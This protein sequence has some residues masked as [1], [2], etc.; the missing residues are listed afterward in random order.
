MSSK[1]GE[2]KGESPPGLAGTS[3]IRSGVASKASPEGAGDSNPITDRAINNVRDIITLAIGHS[4]DRRA[5]LVY[6]EQS[7]LSLLIA[8]SYRQA[9]PEAVR[10]NFDTLTPE[11]ILKAIDQLSGGDLV[12]L[13]Q[14]T[15]FRLNRFRIRL[16]LFKRKLKVIEH[17]HL[18]RILPEEFGIYI[19]SLAYDPEYY[20]TIGP[21]LKMKI[22]YC[23]GI[24]I[25]SGEDELTYPSPFEDAKLNIG[26]YRNMKN[27]GGQF[28][29][30]E[31]FSEPTEIT[32]VNGKVRLFAFG[33]SDF[34]V[35]PAEKPFSAIIEKGV[36]V[37]TEGA[38]KAFL[39]VL[40][41][42]RKS[43][44]RVWLRELGFGL[45]R[46]M[47]RY[48]RVT[49]ISAYE[50]MCGIHLS[51]GGKHSFYTK[52]GFPK[53][54]RYHVDVFVAADRVEIDGE[55]V[56]QDEHYTS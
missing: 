55:I 48:R 50:R 16:E 11:E 6:D 33:N 34:T 32:Q 36:L 27:I 49:D 15:S 17:P 26:D 24:K 52:P 41:E 18:D 35:Y 23:R 43:E 56:F 44:E 5:L 20:R 13:I 28:P 47:N 42:I 31:V 21:L 53:S 25:F 4:P 7:P 30:G 29:I 9:L 2:G 14:S 39:A 51:L 1:Q 40:E 12:V 38:P 22:D 45:N 19:D 8:E 10:L 54:N 37:D 3:S 46:A